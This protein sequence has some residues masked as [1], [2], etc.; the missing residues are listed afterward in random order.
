MEAREETLALP[1]PKYRALIASCLAIFWPGAL[2]FG[3]P[4][5]MAS[6]WQ[7]ALGASRAD[8]GQIIFFMLAGVGLTT[9]LAG[10]AQ[11]RW[12]P[13]LVTALGSLVGAASLVLLVWG[14]GM[15]MVYVWALVNG[16]YGGGV[17]IPAL[18]VAQRWFVARRGLAAGLV[19]MVFGLG[20]AASAPLFSWALA[21]MG[22]TWLCLCLALALLATGLVLTPWLRFPAAAP[23]TGS[24]QAAPGLGVGRAA[25]SLS[26]WALWLTW[27]MGGAAGI[28]MVTLS[29]TFGLARGLDLSGAVVIL[30]CFNLTNGVSRLLSG[31]LSDHLGRNGFMAVT[32]AAAGL[33]YFFLAHAHGL[34]AWAGLAAVIGFA[35]GTL[36]S[37]SAPLA[38]D[39]FGLEHFGA[40]FGL[41]FTAYGF[42][43]GALGPWLAGHLLDLSKGDF[44]LVFAYLGGCMLVSAG[45]V[46]RV[47]PVTGRD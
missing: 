33:A 21:A 14:Q 19:S 38:A 29:T 20:G 40:I 9:Y 43:A 17:Y 46:L 45:S 12:G 10:R 4:G 42:V 39:C 11:E 6:H 37:V 31:W 22:P 2:A 34:W 32:F 3:F 26:F 1:E 27:A 13:G 7:Q 5:V 16:V 8:I 30:A 18:S 47:R 15:A 28:S 25:R 41:V 44:S 23:A 35:F 24:T 36:F